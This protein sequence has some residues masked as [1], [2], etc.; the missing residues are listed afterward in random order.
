MR[1]GGRAAP[2]ALRADRWLSSSGRPSSVPTQKLCSKKRAG[3]GGGGGSSACASPFS[4]PASLSRSASRRSPRPTRTTG[5]AS[6]RWPVRAT[7]RR[8][9]A[10]LRRPGPARLRVTERIVGSRW[11][12]A[13]IAPGGPAQGSG[14][15]LPHV[16][17]RRPMARLCHR[18]DGSHARIPVDCPLRRIGRAPSGRP[19]S[20]GRFRVEPSLRSLRRGCRPA[21]DPSALRASP[22]PSASCHRVALAHPR[23]GAGHCRSRLVSRRSVAGSLDAESPSSFRL[24]SPTRSPPAGAPHGRTTPDS[25]STSSCRPAGGTVGGSCTPSSTTVPFPMAK[26]ASRTPR[27]TRSSAPDATPRLLGETLTN[28]SDGPPSATNTG[29]LTFVSDAGQD[30]RTPWNGKQVEVCSPSVALLLGGPGSRW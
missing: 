12:D 14:S 27:C 4:W 28:D 19:G 16:L 30:P 9:H 24:W 17:T 22:P 6:D 29:L 10:S 18:L 2:C 21:V 20:G 1:R 23:N 8:Q 3:V 11:R 15:D 7:A 13:H 26:A 25:L 5:S